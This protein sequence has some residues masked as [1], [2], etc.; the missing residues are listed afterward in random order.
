[1]TITVDWEVQNQIKQKPNKLHILNF[2]SRFAIEDSENNIVTEESTTSGESPLIKGGTL[3][4]LVE[5]LTYHM[6]ADPKFVRTFLTTYRS[7]CSPQQL[8]D[9]LIER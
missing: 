2:S 9:L 3:I 5:R 4:K 8:L 6:Y 7:F 1:M